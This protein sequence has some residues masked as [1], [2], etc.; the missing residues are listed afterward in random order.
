M[1]RLRRSALPLA[2]FSVLA[3]SACD[4]GPS[5]TR[6][7]ADQ[8]AD[9][10]NV[11]TLTF[12]PEGGTL[13]AVDIR[14]AAFELQ[15]TEVTRP[16]LAVNPN[17]TFTLEYTAKGQFSTVIREGSYS[18]GRQSVTATF[19]NPTQVNTQ[20]LLPSQMTLSFSETPKA[21]SV[22][23]TAPYNVPRADYA[24]LRG[25]DQTNLPA[26]ISGT[27]AATFQKASCS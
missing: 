14:T 16:R 18:L 10:Y 26:Q 22:T 2:A 24:R 27:L 9:S 15:N 20:I 3:L 13:P 25:S 1:L 4:D 17:R 21:L 12:T 5:G 19:S 11:C 23:S 8:V 7:S 6:L